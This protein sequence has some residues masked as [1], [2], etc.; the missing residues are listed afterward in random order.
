MP[1]VI[2]NA[3][4][5]IIGICIVLLVMKGILCWRKKKQHIQNKDF[6]VEYE[7]MYVHTNEIIK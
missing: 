4:F 5:M 2:I 7:V 6:I 3:E 1:D